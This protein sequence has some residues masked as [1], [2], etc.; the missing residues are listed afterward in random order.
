MG[1][2]YIDMSYTL[3]NI[4]YME[5]KTTIKWMW[6]QLSNQVNKKWL[7]FLIKMYPLLLKIKSSSAV[8]APTTCMA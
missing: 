8:Q 4:F 1:L 7:F 2:S 3:I 6:Q 5:M